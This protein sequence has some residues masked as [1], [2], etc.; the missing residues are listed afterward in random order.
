MDTR[1]ARTSSRDRNPSL[2]RAG[3]IFGVVMLASLGVGLVLLQDTPDET[4]TTLRTLEQTVKATRSAATAK[5]VAIPAAD[6]ASASSVVSVTAESA[7]S[8]RDVASNSDGI[9]EVH[10]CDSTDVQPVTYAEA[11][12]SYLARSWEEAADR[13]GRYTES[14]PNNPWGHYMHGL[15]LRQTGDLQ[16]AEAALLRC[17]EIDPDHTK[18]LVNLAR[19]RLDLGRSGDAHEAA[20][21]AVAT[22]PESVDAHRTLARALHSQGLRAEALEEYATVLSL[23]SADAWSLNNR[24]LILIE[25]ERFE[26]AVGSLEQASAID[27]T[28]AVFW[29]NLGVALERTG[30][31]RAAEAAYASAVEQDPGYE[32]A[33]VSLARVTPLGGREDAPVLATPPD[34]VMEPEAVEVASAPG[35]E[36]APNGADGIDTASVPSTGPFVPSS[37]PLGNDD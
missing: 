14:R 35:F 24:G 21:A 30:R 5:A 4:Q 36:L 2:L 12:A 1:T 32:K 10:D 34:A 29:N 8:D 3:I 26:E 17:L 18:S 6:A 20:A 22:D 25:D 11:E 7:V 19:V 16:G 15:A 33:V 23:D 27:A 31:Y 13:F 28:H 9:D 37:S